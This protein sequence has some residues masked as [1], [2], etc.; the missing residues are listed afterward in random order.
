MSSVYQT[1]DISKTVWVE[2]VFSFRVK[3]L[4]KKLKSDNISDCKSV[5]AFYYSEDIGKPVS[6][7]FKNNDNL[8]ISKLPITFKKINFL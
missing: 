2:L 8:N 6:T 3:A 1:G 7:L 4:I 5:C